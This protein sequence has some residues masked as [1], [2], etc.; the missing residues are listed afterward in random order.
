MSKRREPT[1][2]RQFGAPAVA[3]D[4]FLRSLGITDATFTKTKHIKVRFSVGPHTVS[5]SLP[6]TPRDDD[7]AAKQAVRRARQKI[8]EACAFAR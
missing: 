8:T 2:P 5:M 3:V 1:D 7:T 4:E 6:C